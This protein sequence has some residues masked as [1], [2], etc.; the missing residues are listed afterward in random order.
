M[1]RSSPAF[2]LCLAGL[3]MLQAAH[4]GAIRGFITDITSGERVP[5]A[6]VFL[7][8]T[9]TGTM[10]NE[11]GYFYL[12]NLPVGKITIAIG[13]VGY[14]TARQ[15]VLIDSTGVL[16]VDFEL[17]PVTIMMPKTTV[18][19]QRQRFEKAVEISRVQIRGPETGPIPKLGEVDLFRVIQLQPG[20]VAA[21]DFSS[22]LYVRGGSPD[23]NL[24][25]LDGITIFNPSHFGGVFSSFI[26]EA[27]ADAVLYS[28]GFPARYGD[29][30]SSVLA[31]TTKEGN[32][33]KFTGQAGLSMIASKVVIEGPIPKGSFLLAGRRTY[34]DQV[35]KRLPYIKDYTQDFPDYYF[36]DFIG[37][38]NFNPGIST[39][40]SASGLGAE[41]VLHYR[42][43]DRHN[44]ETFSVDVVWG[45]KGVS[46]RVRQV[47]SPKFFGEFTGAFSTFLVRVDFNEKRKMVYR[48]RDAIDDYSLTGEFTYFWRSNHTLE[49]GIAPKRMYFN[50]FLQ[51]D[52]LETKTD[53][54][55]DLVSGY[56]QDRWELGTRF[57][58]QPG[59][60]II[61][62]RPRPV[63][64]GDPRIGFKYLLTEDIA[65]N[66][67]VGRYH[68]FLGVINSQ[69]E[70]LSVFDFWRPVHEKK[71]IPVAYHTILGVERWISDMMSV[72]IEGYYKFYDRLLMLRRNEAFANPEDLA[73]GD[74]YAYGLDLLFKGT[75]SWLSGFA[76]YSYGQTTRQLGREVYHPKYD[77]RH[78]LNLVI[79]FKKIVG[80]DFNLHWSMGTG[81][82]YPGLIAK[83]QHYYHDFGGDSLASS[84]SYLEGPRDAHRLPTYHRLDLSI[85]KGFRIRKVTGSVALDVMNV[86][87]RKNVWFYRWESDNPEREPPTKKP[88]N[89]LPIV[90]SA[91]VTLSF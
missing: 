29:R 23:E 14:E 88:V 44:Q 4:A 36:Y 58:L 80:F 32:R 18:S 78:N 5:Y 52:T 11:K 20:V 8:G 15:D 45:N 9:S 43:M 76:G 34:I 68:Q 75:A 90:P 2:I 66:G 81:F 83:Y 19:A 41:D 46:G 35:I 56:V 22:K 21:S 84:W 55:V 86:Y 85:Q 27:V 65:V 70:L 30:L 26:N 87:N 13:S 54:T 50:Q 73:A 64:L 37:N 24:V 77:R 39:R 69:E 82:P 79:G 33:K 72:N 28:G 10:A 63:V 59:L 57:S 49:F 17:K 40:L 60:R 61:Y 74:G 67:A 7:P 25:L 47:L 91:G 12:G 48:I 31:V 51:F 1:S 62:Y 89:M 3:F 38:V 71:P 6:S 16:S 53:D 42:E